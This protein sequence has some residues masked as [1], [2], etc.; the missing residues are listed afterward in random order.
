MLR[1]S[2]TSITHRQALALLG[3]LVMLF[4]TAAMAGQI[5]VTDIKGRVTNLTG[6]VIEILAELELDTT[7]KLDKNA[8]L[9][10]VYLKDG[11]EYQLK[12][13]S[14]VVLAASGPKGGKASK[15]SS[16]LAAANPVNGKGQK[17]AQGAILMQLFSDNSSKQK[18]Q[19]AIVM[20]DPG[21]ASDWML[22]KEKTLSPS[23]VFEWP[24]SANK[25][26]LTHFRLFETEGMKPI[27]GADLHGNQ[28]TLP[29][30]IKLQAGKAYTWSI[31]LQD[32]ETVGPEWHASFSLATADEMTYF[33]QIRPAPSASFSDRLL[34]A[35]LLQKA[36]FVSDAKRYWQKLAH[37]RPN[38]TPLEALAAP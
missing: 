15:R 33:E 14:E 16:L 5:M 27:I 18:V 19:G 30:N 23:P 4:S 38:L 21:D 36:Q 10:L 31:Q 7:V 1:T 2:I 37:E 3:L 32:G 8:A 20:R 25:Q 22:P 26:A 28:L 17:L 34:Y 9:T 13:A 11:T 29:S 35:H 12:G 24:A 6:Q